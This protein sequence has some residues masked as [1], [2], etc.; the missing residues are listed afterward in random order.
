M[1]QRSRSRREKKGVNERNGGA[2][3]RAGVYYVV[4]LPASN[5][6][7]FP[8]RGNKVPST[9]VFFSV[10]HVLSNTLF[11]LEYVLVTF[12]SPLFGL[13]L[14]RYVASYY[15]QPNQQKIL[16]ILFVFWRDQYH[17]HSSFKRIII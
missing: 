3:A 7:F 13:A 16:G 5:D 4:C 17:V 1:R 8:N 14:A 9:A 10:T 2:L 6:D 15:L 11:C 12:R